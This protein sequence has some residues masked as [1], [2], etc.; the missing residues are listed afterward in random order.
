MPVFYINMTY[1][2]ATTILASIVV[3]AS[4]MV[5]ASVIVGLISASFIIFYRILRK[6]TVLHTNGRI[7]L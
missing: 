2:K 1:K 3:I 4:Q 7:L 5:G 6:L